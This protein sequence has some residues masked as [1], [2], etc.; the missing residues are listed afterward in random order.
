MSK[1]LAKADLQS[2]KTTLWKQQRVGL[3]V[4]KHVWKKTICGGAGTQESCRAVPTAL[5]G[6][7][8]A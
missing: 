1:L 2:I 6:P 5:L 8:G 3:C 4:F 7:F